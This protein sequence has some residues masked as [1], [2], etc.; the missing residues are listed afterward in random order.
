MKDEP[1]A[2]SRRAFV[3]AAMAG[4]LVLAAGGGTALFSG[5]GKKGA[6]EALSSLALPPLPYPANALAPFMSEKTL[7]FHHGRHHANYVKKLGELIKGT[8]YSEM[9]ILAIIRKSHKDPRAAAIFNNAAQ[10]NNH[11]FFWLSMKP[12]GGGVPGGAVKKAIDKSF[13]SQD[14]F[15]KAFLDAASSVFG[16]GWVWLVNDGGKLVVAK[17]QNA[18]TP[19]TSS[20]VPLLCLD[21]WEHAYY[22]DYQD[23]RA[24]YAAAWLDHLV[25]WDFAEKNLAG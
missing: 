25:N 11:A 6:E 21:V 2:E 19:V 13:G 3:K 17:T 4:A 5:C 16:S 23:K 24:D 22:L 18:D 20:A 14:A 10:A 1:F 15:R 7:N 12:K 8:E 9:D